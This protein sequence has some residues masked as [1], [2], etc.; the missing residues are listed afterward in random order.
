MIVY[1]LSMFKKLTSNAF[2]FSTFIF[3]SLFICSCDS[4]S[5]SSSDSSEL[6]LSGLIDGGDDSTT[7]I[8]GQ[9]VD[10]DFQSIVDRFVIEANKRNVSVNLDGLDIQ[11]GIIDDAFGLCSSLENGSK[12]ILILTDLRN[13]PD[14]LKSE[15]LLHELGHC[16]LGREHSDD[17]TSIMHATIIIG[18]PWR[19]EVLDELFNF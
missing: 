17:P 9:G 2:I 5:G 16:I 7:G 19:T 8:S 12:E 1:V 18:Q 6:D 14:D 15:I 4:S 10:P 13:A 11:Y 3:G